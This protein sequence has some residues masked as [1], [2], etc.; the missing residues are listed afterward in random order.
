MSHTPKSYTQSALLISL[1]KYH[2][3]CREI[4]HKRIMKYRN[5]WNTEFLCD[6]GKHFTIDV[7][8]SRGLPCAWGPHSSLSRCRGTFR[9]YRTWAPNLP[10]S[11][12]TKGFFYLPGHPVSV[13]N[14]DHSPRPCL[15]GFCSHRHISDLPPPSQNLSFWNIETP[16][17]PNAQHLCW[18][19]RK[20]QIKALE[21]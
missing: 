4:Q 6:H 20:P 2:K 21:T 3:A 1:H 15:S 10:F 12:V 8:A 18:W 9:E 11:R 14:L 17:G 5:I 19:Q 7:G 16:T 13:M